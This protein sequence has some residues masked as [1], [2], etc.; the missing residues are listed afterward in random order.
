M[1]TGLTPKQRILRTIKRQEIDR[2]PTQID[3]SG[4][5]QDKMSKHWN[6]N[7][8]RE[9]A[10]FLGNHIIYAYLNDAVGNIKARKVGQGDISYD[11]W[12]T[13]FENVSEGPSPVSYPL[14]DMSRWP[15][16]KFPDPN[17]R[18]LLDRA[19]E[20]VADFGDEYL[21]T[22]YQ[23]FSLFERA[24][25]VRGFENFMMDMVVAPDFAET[26]L[27]KITDY[28]VRIAER[29]VNA[30]VACGRIA[31]DYGGKTGMLFSPEMWRALMKPRLKRIFQVYQDA[32]IPV[33]FHCCGHIT[34]I[35]GELAE[36]G[37]SVLHPVQ[38]DAMD[39]NELKTKYG[40]KLVFYGGISTSGSLPFGTAA[41]VREDVR[42]AVDILGKDGGYIVAPA[43]GITSD[44]SAE[45]IEALR[46]AIVEF[47]D[48]L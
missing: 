36:L 40:K 19:K 12:G 39:I 48:C 41:E 43:Q 24:W 47:T 8:D 10:P 35:V 20:V 1:S 26:L 32:G 33:L 25:L 44:V 37:V 27:D 45:N 17:E 23:I 42:H 4:A 31:D 29:Y 38:P 11:D 9:M 30:G 2:L 18:G 13:G 3:F 21:V 7:G 16:Y 34:P 46:Q 22:S 5:C 28:S 14:V 15:S 6:L